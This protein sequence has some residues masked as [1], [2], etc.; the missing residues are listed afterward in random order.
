MCSHSQAK[1]LDYLT[2]YQ[3]VAATTV[4]DG[5][6]TTI[7]N[8]EEDVKQVVALN[9]VRVINLCTQRS[10]HN[11]GSVLV[12]VMSAK[13]LLLTHLMIIV[14]SGNVSCINIVIL[15]IRSTNIPTI[16]SND[17]GTFAQAFLLHVAKSLVAV[18]PDVG[19]M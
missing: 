13:D 9:L 6:N 19:G 18:A 14:V 4:D 2:V 7:I 3:V 11:D 5:K 1:L 12:R 8:D 15:N 10:L 16:S 17:V